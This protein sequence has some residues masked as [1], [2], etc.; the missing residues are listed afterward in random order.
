MEVER[1]STETDSAVQFQAL[2]AKGKRLLSLGTLVVLVPTSILFYRQGSGGAMFKCRFLVLG[3]PQRSALAPRAA[4][5]P[6]ESTPVR[7]TIHFAAFGLDCSVLVA[8][9]AGFCLGCE[10]SRLRSFR[11]VLG[12][13]ACRGDVGGLVSS[14]GMRSAPECLA[15]DCF[16][17]VWPLPLSC[18]VCVLLF[19][20]AWF[21]GCRHLVLEGLVR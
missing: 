1:L 6:P 11:R 17:L 20:R 15:A 16:S 2:W 14:F 10:V 13:L 8:F 4:H 5:R 12:L 3:D 7:C 18:H 19:I 21:R 9:A